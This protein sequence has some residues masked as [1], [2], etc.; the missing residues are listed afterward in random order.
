MDIV[1]EE[2][3]RAIM[4]Y[5][6]ALLSLLIEAEAEHQLIDGHRDES[7]MVII[8]H[9]IPVFSQDLV[10]FYTYLITVISQYEWNLQRRASGLSVTILKSALES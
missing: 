5:L 3:R 1:V 7:C 2:G 6:L 9:H 4:P 10:H 8:T